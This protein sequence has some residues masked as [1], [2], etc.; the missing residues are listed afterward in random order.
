MAADDLCFLSALDLRERFRRRELSPVAV[1]EAVLARI[2]RVNPRLTAFVTVTPELA[3]AQAEA[4][5][6]A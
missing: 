4:A 3:I 5:E 1:T 6:R 2:E